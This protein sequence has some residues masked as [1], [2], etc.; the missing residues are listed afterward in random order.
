M[1]APEVAAL[2]ERIGDRAPFNVARDPVTL[3]MIRRWCDIVGDANP[4]YTDTVW[5]ERSVFRGVIAPPAMMDVFDKPGF[6]FERN[7][8]DPQGATIQALEGFGFTSTVAV[9]SE[10]EFDRHLRIGELV[11]STIELEDVSEEKQTGLGT[12]HFVTSRLRYFAGDDQV[13]SVLFRILKF[14]PGTGRSST[15]GAR[16]GPATAAAGVTDPGP[17]RAAGATRSPADLTDGQALPD[18]EIPITTTLIVAGALMTLDYFDAHHDR[19][20]AI[21]RGSKDV[22]MN[23]HTTAGLV[24]RY[25]NDW[26][27]PEAVWRS[28]RLRLGAPNYPHDVMT[29]RGTVSAVDRAT[30]LVEV[31]LSGINSLGP[32][33]TGTA[34]LA[35]PGGTA[36]VVR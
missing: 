23:I 7:V 18:V 30:G 28:L 33:V 9:N 8:D 15:G 14:R 3:F 25:V 19:E 21:R 32:H 24:A 22:F 20:M 27:G 34:E 16:P 2:R 36:H 4:A 29:M 35:L 10:L 26:V 6:V 11:H 13:G 17:A 1:P 31:A 5:A 12:G